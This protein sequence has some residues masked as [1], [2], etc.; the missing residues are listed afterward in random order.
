MS[1]AWWREKGEKDRG[2][3]KR[4]RRRSRGRLAFRSPTTRRFSGRTSNAED[5]LH[6]SLSLSLSLYLYLSFSFSFSFSIV[7]SLF[8]FPFFSRC[9]SN[10][11]RVSALSCSS[12]PLSFSR[13]CSPSL[14]GSC[15][16][17]QQQCCQKAHAPSILP[18][19]ST[20]IT[21]I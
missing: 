11:S 2:Q 18:R 6:H 10:P 3:K 7:L 9:L 5:K 16:C 13:Q 15:H 19:A 14:S 4:Q 17:K 20:K 12:T 1:R 21:R 8:L